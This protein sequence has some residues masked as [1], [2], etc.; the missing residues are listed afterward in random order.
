[1]VPPFP[2]PPP[3]PP[4]YHPEPPA[5]AQPPHADGSAQYWFSILPGDA[6]NASAFQIF[7]ITLYLAHCVAVH[8]AHP[9]PIE[10]PPVPPLPPAIDTVPVV[11]YEGLTE[12]HATH[13]HPAPVDTPVPHVQPHS[14]IPQD[15]TTSAV[16][17]APAVSPEAA[18]PA[19][20][21]LIILAVPVRVRVPSTY[22]ANHA[23]SRVTPVFT[24][25]LL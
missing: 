24:V 7:R 5:H 10:V 19:L 18:E 9:A 13:A 11:A 14:D 3:P 12:T 17:P 16:A 20:P 4:P 22:I 15:H 21:F 8:A 25:R 1:M 2:P 23:G 6:S